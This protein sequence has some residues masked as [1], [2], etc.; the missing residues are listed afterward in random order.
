M[1]QLIYLMNKELDNKLCITSLIGIV[2]FMS[3]T[4]LPV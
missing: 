2:L 3:E 1:H 4:K